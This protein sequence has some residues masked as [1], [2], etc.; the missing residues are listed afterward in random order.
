LDFNE[1]ISFYSG[2]ELRFLVIFCLSILYSTREK[3]WLF[4]AGFV[5]RS[6][7]NARA[8]GPASILV[9][10][11]GHSAASVSF[12][13]GGFVRLRPRLVFS[14]SHVPPDSSFP[15]PIFVQPSFPLRGDQ[16][17]CSAFN[18]H[19]KATN[20]QLG[21]PRSTSLRHFSSPDLLCYSRPASALAF[22]AQ[23]SRR[24]PRLLSSFGSSVAGKLVPVSRHSTRLM[25]LLCRRPAEPLP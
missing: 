7:A 17:T 3:L 22:V 1:G 2:C 5:I 18:S 12:S 24:C 19:P 11:P 23:W 4:I 15:S 14:C 20:L 9:L 25:F 6:L 21:R 10:D 8:L 13:A 16:I